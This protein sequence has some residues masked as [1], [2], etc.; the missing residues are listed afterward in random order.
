[1]SRFSQNDMEHLKD[2]MQRGMMTSAQ[3]NVVMVRMSRV[4]VVINSMPRDVRNALRDAVKSG[5]LCHKKKD[6]RK[7]EVFYHPDFEH[8]ANEERDNVEREALIALTG[9][10]AR[11]DD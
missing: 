2:M 4:R 11:K 5:E 10:L 7:P 6:G 9:V 3:A 1:M 8:L